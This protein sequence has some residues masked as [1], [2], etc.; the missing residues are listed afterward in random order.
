MVV[1]KC[2]Q[3]ACIIIQNIVYLCKSILD[4]F[5][6]VITS[7]ILGASGYAGAELLR[8]LSLRNDL[9]VEKVIAGSAAGRRVDELYPALARQ[10][11]LTFESL[12]PRKI[13]GIDVAFVALPSGEAMNVVPALLQSTKHVIDLSGD[14]RLDSRNLYEQYYK[15]THTAS[16]LLGK[17][18]YG[19][20]EL[21]KE[22]VAKARL[23]ANPGCYPTSA[24]LALLPALVHD[25]VSSH[26]IVINSLSG[27]SGAGRSASFDLSFTEINEN[28]RAYRTTGHQHIP[29]I[30]SVLSAACGRDVTISFVPYLIP[31]N[32][33][34]YTTVLADLNP[35]VTS[36]E[37]SN[38]YREYYEH[39][40]FVRLKE[41]IPQ[42]RDVVNT[43]YCDIGLTIDSRAN[44]LM[45]ISVIDNLVKGAAGQAIQNMNIVFGLPETQG[46]Q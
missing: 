43:N 38:I 27:V 16:H 21:N 34:I 33:G 25:L 11:S 32:R 18:V 46:L 3:Q 39:A 1:K 10:V 45:I 29:E 26:G 9:R 17:A 44:K 40:P 22:L 12:D 20:P 15:H 5:H 14:F 2:L 6:T 13:G 28:V 31:I 36:S 4:E 24:I 7:I 42:I 23:I 19:L 37:V 30:E 35:K 41:Q 8:I